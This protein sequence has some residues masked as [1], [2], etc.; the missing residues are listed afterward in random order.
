M[1][2]ML[3]LAPSQTIF[4]S[5]YFLCFLSFPLLSYDC[6]I[7]P[8]VELLSGAKIFIM[9][10][11]CV[12]LAQSWR[13]RVASEKGRAAGLGGLRGGL[14]FIFFLS[15]FEPTV[16]FSDLFYVPATPTDRCSTPGHATH[17]F[18]KFR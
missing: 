12:A 1:P 17:S 16:H 10:M 5:S 3:F 14:R 13:V 2:V 18:S 9:R 8:P 6:T 11:Q 15:N 4:P 7:A